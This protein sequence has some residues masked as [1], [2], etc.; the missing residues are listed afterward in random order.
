MAA[1]G[2]PARLHN[3][4]HRRRNRRRRHGNLQPSI[5]HSTLGR[6]TPAPSLSPLLHHHNQARFSFFP[7]FFNQSISLSLSLSLSLNSHLTAVIN[8]SR[9]LSEAKS[10][11]SPDQIPRNK[12]LLSYLL[13]DPF[14]KHRKGIQLKLSPNGFSRIQFKAAPNRRRKSPQF[15]STLVSPFLFCFSLPFPSPNSRTRTNLSLSLS[16][17]LS[18]QSLPLRTPSESRALPR[19]QEKELPEQVAKIGKKKRGWRTMPFP[20]SGPTSSPSSRSTPFPVS[21]STPKHHLLFGF[22]W[23]T[24]M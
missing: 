8:L 17:S 7:Y 24:A 10:Y 5:C 1:N 19:S 12:P 22:T 23:T 21:V 2:V 13:K 11:V 16:L 4:H 6:P 9:A 20:V 15:S 3:H 18:S 14:K